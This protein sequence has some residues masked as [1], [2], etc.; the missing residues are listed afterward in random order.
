ML[1]DKHIENVIPTAENKNLFR[2]NIYNHCK[3]KRKKEKFYSCSS[4]YIQICYSLIMSP[5]DQLFYDYLSQARFQKV[6]QS[7]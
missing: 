7:L 1:Q 4:T 5:L 3:K 2:Q 6:S